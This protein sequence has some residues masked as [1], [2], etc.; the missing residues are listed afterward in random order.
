[1][2]AGPR[3]AR[4]QP[5]V[6]CLQRKAWKHVWLYYDCIVVFLHRILHLILVK[7]YSNL[8]AASAIAGITAHLIISPIPEVST[9]K[10][11]LAYTTANASLLAYLVISQTPFSS[12]LQS[13][14][15]IT[16]NLAIANLVFLS[17]SITVTLIRRLYFSPLSHFPGPKLAALSKVWLSNQYR[18]GQAAK[19]YRRLHRLYNSEVIRIGP[20]EL[21][22]DCVEAVEKIYKGKYERG[23]FYEL[24]AVNGE[25][26]L[27]TTRD[28]RLHSVWRR[29]W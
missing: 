15:D 14:V 26:N 5:H 28:Y 18:T 1:M 3:R 21:S 4:V 10:V 19:T 7:M 2:G 20:N 16:I 24:G 22:I 13:L 12:L 27:N 11:V 25:S 6:R 9:V 29:I 17:V 8:L 23:P